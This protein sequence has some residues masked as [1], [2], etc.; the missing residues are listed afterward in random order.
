[1]ALQPKSLII[2]LISKRNHAEHRR[3]VISKY[4]IIKSGQMRTFFL[5]LI[6]TGLFGFSV[7]GQIE[8]HNVIFGASVGTA[9]SS[10]S[11]NNS[12]KDGFAYNIVAGYSIS[13][14]L[15]AG[16]EYSGAYPGSTEAR[17]QSGVNGLENY[18]LNSYMVKGWYKITTWTVTPY[19]GI[20][21]G[22]ATLKEPNTFINE[23][24][25][26]GGSRSGFAASG[27]IG[28]SYGQ[29]ILSYSYIL[30]GKTPKET[31]LNSAYAD[32]SVNMQRI[33]IGF[34]YN[35]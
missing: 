11:F 18:K 34:I 8:F 10:K 25:Y 24:E 7:K 15:R 30:N 14:Q 5:L 32:K 9:I 2:K 3:C 29:L 26:K 20:G 35:F 33:T 23:I 12:I 28:I 19:V 31:F 17:N 22:L 6:L 21:L 1:M 16:I 4:S 13:H 27:E